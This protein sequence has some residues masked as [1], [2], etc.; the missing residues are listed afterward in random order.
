MSS[1]VNHALFDL[2]HSMT[3]SEKRYFKLLSSRHTIGE[4]NNY[5]RIFDYLD[6]QEEYDEDKLFKDF[7]GESFL[8]RFSITKK[9]LYD[10]VLSAL[11]S[12]HVSHSID[13]QLHKMLHSSN[14]LFEKSLYDQSRRILVSAEK[15]ARKHERSHILLQVLAKR[16]NV[17]ETHG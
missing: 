3:K 15:L 17:I 12:F 8:N 13:A 16:K 9:R 10:H 6:K 2:I 1:K 14:I 11:D 4:E 5:V 7:K